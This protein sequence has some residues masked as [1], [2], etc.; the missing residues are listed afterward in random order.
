MTD[1]KILNF[2]FILFFFRLTFII[3]INLTH[4]DYREAIVAITFSIYIKEKEKVY[5]T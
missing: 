5:S 3:I 4:C 1:E 2:C